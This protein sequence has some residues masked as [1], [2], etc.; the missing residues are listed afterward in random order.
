M[1]PEQ[2]ISVT[3]AI[4]KIRGAQIRRACNNR[5]GSPLAAPALE[6]YGEIIPDSVTPQPRAGA[7]KERVYGKIDNPAA[8]IALNQLRRLR[9]VHALIS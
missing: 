3:G 2:G 9:N 8:H 5:A 1:S 7:E 6:Y 4:F